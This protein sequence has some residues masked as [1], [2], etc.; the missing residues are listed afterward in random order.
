MAIKLLLADASARIIFKMTTAAITL[1]S[2]PSGQDDRLGVHS[3]GK[4]R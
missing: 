4:T 2:D 3:P 1:H